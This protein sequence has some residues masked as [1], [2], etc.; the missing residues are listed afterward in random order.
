MAAS[1]EIGE[2]LTK[3]GLTKEKLLSLT[4][5]SSTSVTNQVVLDLFHFMNRNPSCT[6]HTLSQWLSIL[7][8]ERCP[9]EDFPTV[10]AIRQSVLRLCAKLCKLQKRHASE[11]S[12][13]VTTEFLQGEYCLPCVFVSGNTVHKV[14][15]IAK[16]DEALQAVNVDLCKEL[17]ELKLE[18]ESLKAS[19]EQLAKR[20]KKCTL[21]RNTSKMLQRR[22]KALAAQVDISEM[23]EQQRKIETFLE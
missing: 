1:A 8:G 12:K 21:H 20:A 19:E 5:G 3:L 14:Q 17:A 4:F 9:K 15:N 23:V 22:E 18:N 2:S 13:D 16:S 7:F 11:S 6:Y 10:K